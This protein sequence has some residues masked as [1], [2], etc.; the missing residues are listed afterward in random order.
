VQQPAPPP[1]PLQLAEHPRRIAMLAPPWIPVPPPGYGA[2]EFVLSL[3]CDALVARGHDVELFCAPGSSSRA[4]VRPLLERPHP[5][6][7]ERSVFEADHVACGFGE[8]DAAARAGNPFELVNDHCGY[9]ALAMADRLDVPL[10]HTVHGPF[11]DATGPFYNRHGS[12]GT[13]VCISHSQA[14]SAPA[15]AN[16]GGVVHNP[17][18]VAS[19]PVGYQKEEWLLWLGRIVPEKGPHRAIRVGRKA[20]RSCSPATCSR[21][22]SASSPKR[23][24]RTSTASRCATSARWAAPA[25]S[26]CSPTRSPS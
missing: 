15:G 9:T 17:I 1:A 6:S 21:A 16:V 2:I 24:C 3:L 10:T 11:D 22:T 8:I 23:C 4:K 5:E 14:S 18:D 12:K 26:A 19:W 25:S 7:I 13:L 20:G